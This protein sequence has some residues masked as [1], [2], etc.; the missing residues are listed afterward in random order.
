[1]F[2]DVLRKMIEV[3]ID[4]ILIIPLNSEDHLDHLS[5]TF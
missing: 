3:Y 1:M 5:Q 2:K 4:D